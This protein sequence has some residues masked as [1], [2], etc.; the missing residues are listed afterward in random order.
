VG[1]TDAG[2]GEGG[3]DLIDPASL[4]VARNRPKEASQSEPYERRCNCQ[5]KRIGDGAGQLA[6]HGPARQDGS[7]QVPV[8]AL[9]SQRRYWMGIG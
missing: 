3:H 2:D 8:A 7:A 9:P 4:V 1:N 6:C 5:D